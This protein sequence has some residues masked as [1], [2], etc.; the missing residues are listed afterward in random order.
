MIKAILFDY[1]GTLSNR[2]RA[3]YDMYKDCVMRM[4]PELDPDGIEL[5]SI[6]QHSII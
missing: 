3:A 5:E 4:K 2:R 6:V 1:D